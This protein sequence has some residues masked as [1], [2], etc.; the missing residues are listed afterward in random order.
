MDKIRYIFHN[1]FFITRWGFI[2]G[3]ARGE[4]WN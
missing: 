2:P 4:K 3:K 1:L